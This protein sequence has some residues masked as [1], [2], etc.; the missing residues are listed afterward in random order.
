MS[1]MCPLLETLESRRL[2]SAVAPMDVEQ[3]LVCLVNRG[4]ADPAAEAARYHIDLNE[5]LA[6]GT[7][8]P[9]PKQPLAI[10][11]QITDA[12]RGHSQ[13]MLDNDLFQ[14]NGP[15]TLT[16]GDRMSLS[17]YVFAGDWTWGENIGY[18]GTTGPAPDPYVTTG[19][20]QEDLFV[21]AGIADRGHRIDLM[22]PA[23]KQ[24]GAGVVSGRFSIYNAVMATQDFAATAG[25]SFLTGVAY[26]DTVVADQFY[27]P[28]E[29]LAAVTLTARRVSDQAVFSTQSFS[30]GG[31]NLQLPPGVYDIT[32]AGGG[33]ARA[34]L[35]SG[36]TMGSQN[37]LMDIQPTA[38]VGITRFGNGQVHVEGSDAGDSIN[39]NLFNG[40]LA[41]GLNQTT[42]LFNLSD[43]TSLWIQGFGGDD[44]V[45]VDPALQLSATIQGGLGN[46]WLAGGAADD[47][48]QGGGGN[49]MIFGY[50]G[51]DTL[52][53]GAN[54]D[55]LRGGMGDDFIFGG[56]GRDEVR[57]GK[58]NDWLVGGAE[59]DT[60]FGGLGYNFSP[61]DAQDLLTAITVA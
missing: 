27:T 58:G 53:G 14:H 47:L 45:I 13:W 34:Q 2:L 38:Q 25:N 43:V 5:G 18:R 44:Q 24:I 17:G 56:L 10:D 46:D 59:A 35:Y 39:V 16:P 33:L 4:R 50:G 42:R 3:Y 57:G 15:G 49:D 9:V 20:L 11:F 12:A 40:Q 48:I 29:G 7:I 55:Q 19:K 52:R 37:V 31:Y 54:D 28:G 1:M 23:F 41:V 26:A 36:I 32:A 22:N 60:L 8:S 6:G 61:A 21:D 30:T 51:N